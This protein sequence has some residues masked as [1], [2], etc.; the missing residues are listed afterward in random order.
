MGKKRSLTVLIS[1]VVF[2]VA[3]IIL[4][5]AAVGLPPFE[6][7]SPGV[8]LLGRVLVVLDGVAIVVGLGTIL[9]DA[10]SGWVRA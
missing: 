5:G 8:I 1:L 7:W 3:T 4:M 10:A 6:E 9:Y 2:E